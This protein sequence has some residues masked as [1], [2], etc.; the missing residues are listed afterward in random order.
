MKSILKFL[1]L[2]AALL[3][4]ASAM[5]GKKIDPPIANSGTVGMKI[6]V[7]STDN[8]LATYL[9]NSAM[10]SNDLYLGDRLIF[11][12]QDTVAPTTIDLGS[13]A[14]GTELV[15]T[16]K[17]AQTG[18]V[19]SS[20]DGSRNS[21]KL[22]HARVQQDWQGGASLVS[23]EDLLGNPEGLNGYNDMS[24]SLTHTA[25][26]LKNVADVATPVPEPETYGMLLAGLGLIGAI[27]RRKN[28]A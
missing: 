17:V 6:I 1:T 20:G 24:F 21:D 7:T 3:A 22:A 4:S 11:N 27:G 2:S 12:N 13:F 26:S 16:M 19:F 28:A 15:F 23:F 14:V 5:A 18:D 8:V 9:G 10:Y 25:T